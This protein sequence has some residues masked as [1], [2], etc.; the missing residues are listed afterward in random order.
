[1][2][3]HPV[4]LDALIRREDFEVAIDPAKKIEAL[5]PADKL[6]IVELEQDSFMYKLLRKADFQRT[7]AHWPPE[8]VAGFIKS[9]L[10]GDLIPALILWRSN[11]SGNIFVIDGAHRLSALIARVHDD[12][13]DRNISRPFFEGRI[14]PEQSAAAE[15][16]RKIINN[17]VGS[18]TEV[19]HSANPTP[20]RARFASNLA[21]GGVT[22]QW[23]RGDA[24]RAERSFHTIN[25][26]QTPIGDLEVRLIRDR[27]CPNA[28]ATRALVRAGTGQ[29]F[30][31]TLSDDSKSRIKAL[32]K[33]I[34]DDLF[35]PPLET[36]MKT[37][38]LPVAGGSYTSDSIELIL[39]FVEF[40]NKPVQASP[41]EVRRPR[42]K[43]QMDILAPTMPEDADGTATVGFLTNV[44]KASSQIAGTTPGSLDLH[45]AVYFYSATGNYQPT[46]FLLH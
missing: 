44:R 6:K 24:S 27:R 18:Y 16:T 46:A 11:A 29:Y 43:K 38:D 15:E 28:I 40:V 36:P 13:G 35:V 42:R 22:L 7:T 33:N 31:S 37:L 17:T 19:K 41:A 34:Y 45:P 21:A 1:M 20:E 32:A 30:A 12:Y 3:I 4:N 10:A 8:K 9:F 5:D 25:T 14:V 26:E 23:V 39:D 2:A